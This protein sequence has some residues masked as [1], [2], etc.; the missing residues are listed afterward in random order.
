MV[1]IEIIAKGTIKKREELQND[2]NRSK[3]LLE[4]TDDP[5]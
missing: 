5:L 3:H 4:N 2:L 1:Y